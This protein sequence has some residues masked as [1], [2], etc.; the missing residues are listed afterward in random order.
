MDHI[1]KATEAESA[2]RAQLLEQVCEQALTD[3]YGRGVVVHHGTR[4][5]S[6]H[7]SSKVPFGVILAYPL[8]EDAQ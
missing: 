6:C 5:F 8:E 4:T 7:L 1:T 3:P 2:R